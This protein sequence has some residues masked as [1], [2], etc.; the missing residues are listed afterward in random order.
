MIEMRFIGLVWSGCCF[1]MV[2][3][4]GLNLVWV[5]CWRFLEFLDCWWCGMLIGEWLVLG[6]DDCEFEFYLYYLMNFM[7]VCFWNVI[8]YWVEVISGCGMI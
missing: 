2:E 8:Y 1:V 4:I 6:I 3:I 5:V 7:I